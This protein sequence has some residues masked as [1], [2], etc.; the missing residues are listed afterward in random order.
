MRRDTDIYDES[1]NFLHP[2]TVKPLWQ[3]L[4]RPE[5]AP[6][7]RIGN[8]LVPNIAGGFTP[9]MSSG[10]HDNAPVKATVLALPSKGYLTIDYA[11]HPEGP[12]PAN[13]MD[14]GFCDY[15][16]AGNHMVSRGMNPPQHLMT[17]KATREDWVKAGLGK[18]HDAFCHHT[19]QTAKK[20]VPWR[21]PG[22]GDTV[23]FGYKTWSWPRRDAF[24]FPD[25]IYC[26]EPADGS[27]AWAMGRVALVD[28][29]LAAPVTESG[30]VV[31]HKPAMEDGRGV[32]RLVGDGF[33]SLQPGIRP[34]MVVRFPVH[35]QG[36]PVIPNP[37]GSQDMCLVRSDTILCI[38]RSS[39]D[40]NQ[41]RERERQ[42]AGIR[43]LV[44]REIGG[45]VTVG[46]DDPDWVEKEREEA[47]TRRNNKEFHRKWS[48]RMVH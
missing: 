46:S 7:E 31:S 33:A 28:Q 25:S 32:V 4:V 39:V 11:E 42:A 47:M 1:G 13:A 35:G 8:I 6:G 9:G 14:K 44:D 26:V 29:L 2:G 30:I 17:H 21:L 43:E 18:I 36:N 38:E 24:I 48:R 45:F 37:F 23:W 15:A 19:P 27:P 10:I 3:V 12:N 34:G 40:M 5:P 20:I 41:Q 22:V 16:A